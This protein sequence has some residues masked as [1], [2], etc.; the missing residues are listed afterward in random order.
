MICLVIY[1]TN[2]IIAVACFKLAVIDTMC[3]PFMVCIPE[4]TFLDFPE[5]LFPDRC[6]GQANVNASRG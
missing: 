3:H 6:P 1:I 5:S 2:S 4:D